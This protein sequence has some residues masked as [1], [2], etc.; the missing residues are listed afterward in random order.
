MSFD[1]QL[2]RFYLIILLMSEWVRVMDG[3]SRLCYPY[4]SCVAEL[5]QM[6]Q[7]SNG[8]ER[9]Y[10]S[11]VYL[12]RKT[13]KYPCQK[14]F[15]H[16]H[17]QNPIRSGLKPLIFEIMILIPLMVNGHKLSNRASL[18]PAISRISS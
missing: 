5:I 7:T 11:I 10:G 1:L 14:C 16:E 8:I 12:W 13:C 4:P 15:L 2:T 17:K 6:I 18:G 9:M 3:P